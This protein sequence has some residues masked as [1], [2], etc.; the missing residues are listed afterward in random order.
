MALLRQ[1]LWILGVGSSNCRLSSTTKLRQDRSLRPV[2]YEGDVL[3]STVAFVMLVY[4]PRLFCNI[5]AN[6]RWPQA[7]P[8]T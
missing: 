8:Q 2:A 4:G 1:S 6:P 5:A 3:I 7:I